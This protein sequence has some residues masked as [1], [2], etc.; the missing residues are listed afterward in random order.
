MCVIPQ[1][2]SSFENLSLRFVNHHSS[3]RVSAAEDSVR[4]QEEEPTAAEKVLL[5]EEFI[6][7]MHQRFLDGKDKDFNYRSATP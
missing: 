7:Q 1:P 3:P 2:L 4:L 5:R 6:S